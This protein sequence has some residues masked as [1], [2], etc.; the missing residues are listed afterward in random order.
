MGKVATSPNA[1][2]TAIIII[3][4]ALVLA[5]VNSLIVTQLNLGFLRSRDIVNALHDTR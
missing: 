1:R 5:L 3:C 2:H 4:V